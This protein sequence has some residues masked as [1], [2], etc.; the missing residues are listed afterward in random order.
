MKNLLE[1]RL[2]HNLILN[3]DGMIKKEN[4]DWVEKVGCIIFGIG[5]IALL[6]LWLVAM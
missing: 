4:R 6:W 3:E 2:F 5:I 1:K